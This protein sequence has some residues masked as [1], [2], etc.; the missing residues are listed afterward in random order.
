VDRGRD[1]QV[2]EVLITAVVVIPPTAVICLWRGRKI[3]ER[4]F[5]SRAKELELRA[6]QIEIDQIPTRLYPK[7]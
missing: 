4:C 2:I 3:A 5:D 6:E 7:R 1:E